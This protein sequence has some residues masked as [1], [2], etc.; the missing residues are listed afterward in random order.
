MSAGKVIFSSPPPTIREPHSPDWY[1]YEVS[2]VI[3]VHV[4][5]RR[6]RDENQEQWQ[7]IVCA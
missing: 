2:V 3:R 1:G 6:A 7:H 4:Q 5:S